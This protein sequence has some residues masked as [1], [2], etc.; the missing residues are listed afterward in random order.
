MLDRILLIF[1]LVSTA[2]SFPLCWRS[3]YTTP[4]PKGP[5]SPHVENYSPIS[6]TSVLSRVYERL[7]SA[8]LGKFFQSNCVLLSQ[9]MPFVRVL[10]RVTPFSMYLTSCR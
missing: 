3:A 1:S 6:I 2:G 9:S 5:L 7:L 10:A 4:V 8:R